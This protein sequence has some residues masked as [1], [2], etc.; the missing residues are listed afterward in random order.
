MTAQESADLKL[1]GALGAI[2]RR[3]QAGH[4]A[5]NEFDREGRLVDFK[6]SR[7]VLPPPYNGGEGLRTLLEIRLGSAYT[8]FRGDDDTVVE[9]AEQNAYRAL[10]RVLYQ[11]VLDDLMPIMRAVGDGKRSE[12][13]RLLNNLYVR[14]NGRE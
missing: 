6:A 14:L 1:R 4:N 10:C 13:L 5:Y 12:A 9:K 2:E 11:D 8:V 3:A 7:T